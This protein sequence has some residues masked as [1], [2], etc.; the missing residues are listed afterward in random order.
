M[1]GLAARSSGQRWPRPRFCCASF[2]RESPLCTLTVFRV[3]VAAGLRADCG[4]DGRTVAASAA[5]L[6]NVFDCLG[7]DRTRGRIGWMR[8][9]GGAGREEILGSAGA[10]RTP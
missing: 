1:F 6:A 4:F 2:Q 5:G 9:L 10:I 3:A 7:M 8:I